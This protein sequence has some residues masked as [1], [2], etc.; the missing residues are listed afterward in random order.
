[1]QRDAF[2]ANIWSAEVVL[3]FAPLEFCLTGVFEY[4]FAILSSVFKF[5]FWPIANYL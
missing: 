5:R 3:P 4:Q 1:M 2:S